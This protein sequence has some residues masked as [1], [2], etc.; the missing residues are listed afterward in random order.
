[1][2]MQEIS[3]KHKNSVYAKN[4]NAFDVKIWPQPKIDLSHDTSCKAPS[5]R[6]CKLHA[7]Y[8]GFLN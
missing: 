1:V 6:F 7:A 4:V 5:A 3:S 2:Q 8:A